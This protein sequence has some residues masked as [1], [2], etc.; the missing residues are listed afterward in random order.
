MGKP[1]FTFS[2]NHAIVLR[3]QNEMISRRSFLVMAA[4]ATSLLGSLGL[5]GSRLFAPG[6]SRLAFGDRAFASDYEEEMLRVAP[7]ARFWASVASAGRDCR[8]CHDAK[9]TLTKVP[10]T[11]AQNLVKCLLCARQCVILPGSRGKC[12]ARKNVDG[13]LRSLVYGRPI[14]VHTDPI[15]KKPFYHYLPGSAAHSLATSGCPLTCKFCQNWQIS[16]ASPEDYQAPF[17][18][19]ASVVDG[20]SSRTAPVIAFTYNEPTVFTEYMLDIAMEARKRRIRSV[21]VSCGFMNE[22]PLKEMCGVLGAIKIDLKGFSDQFYRDVCGAELRPVL[23]SIKQIAKSRAH[24]E[25]VNLVVPTLNDSEKMLEGLA[26]WVVGEL[27]P[28]VPVHFTRF[29]PD[30]QMPHLPPTPVETLEHARRIALAKGMRYAYVG[31]VPGHP[32]NN[33]YCPSCGKTVIKRDSFFLVEM[34]L[35]EGRCV[36]CDGKI[37]GVWR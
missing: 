19:P 18:P 14:A 17:T 28:D 22:A 24:L 32:G 6:T 8:Q 31:N 30:Y 5:A 7:R 33:T 1:A 9:E 29:H 21:L 16:Q 11:H 23:R 2:L 20:A 12:R 10:H 4:K 27:G 3:K 26:D 35:K 15:E 13:Q 37:A 36:Y 25:I 34:H